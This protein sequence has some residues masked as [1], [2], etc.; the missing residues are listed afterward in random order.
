MSVHFVETPKAGVVKPPKRKTVKQKKW[1]IKQ[2]LD[3]ADFLILRCYF[4]KAEKL[5][6]KILKKY[7]QSA[8][9]WSK[10][11]LVYLKQY[12]GAEAKTAFEK[13]KYYNPNQVEALYHLGNMNE[14][15]IQVDQ[16][17]RLTQD[18]YY[19]GL[20]NCYFKELPTAFEA[21]VKGY[22]INLGT[23][24][25]GLMQFALETVQ[26]Y[27]TTANVASELNFKEAFAG[28]IEQMNKMISFANKHFRGKSKIKLI[29]KHTSSKK[30]FARLLLAA[31]SICEEA[32][33][34]NCRNE[35]AHYNLGMIYFVQEKYEQARKCFER[36]VE[37]NPRHAFAH[38]QLGFLSLIEEK[39]EEA[40]KHFRQAHK[41][42]KEGGM[43]KMFL[44]KYEILKDGIKEE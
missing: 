26:L 1:E 28:V 39:T 7:P 31:K 44:E 40:E 35:S 42:F 10:L 5:L 2:V 37:R 38:L 27:L 15:L 6:K 16:A 19:L 33:R 22:E 3:F 29:A 9:L 25:P 12:K 17:C 14:S 32:I 8:S 23:D 13:A 4:D 20:C 11:G 43:E 34:D 41:L 24:H 21:F 18:P 36:T 30:A